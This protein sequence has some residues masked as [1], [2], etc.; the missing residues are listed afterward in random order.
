MEGN[1]PLNGHLRPLNRIVLANDPV[2]AGATCARLMGLDPTRITHI[3]IGAQ[4]LGNASTERIDQVA[5]PVFT[6][7]NPFEF[8]PEFLHL[9]LTVSLKRASFYDS[10]QK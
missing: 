5:E 10:Q 8:V 6:P 7:A 9:R 4:F 1:G 2:A 3:R